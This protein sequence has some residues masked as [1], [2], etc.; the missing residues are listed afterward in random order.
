MLPEE[1]H[2]LDELRECFELEQTYHEQSPAADSR[3]FFLPG[4][5]FSLY[6]SLWATGHI[7]QIRDESGTLCAAL[8]AVPPG[9]EI[10]TRLFAAPGMNLPT[11]SKSNPL[12]PERSV[13]IAKIMTHPDWTRQGLARQLYED[14]FDKF[15]NYTFVTA[16]ALSP[17]RNTVS[18]AFHARIGFLQ[19]GFFHGKKSGTDE[20]TINTL[21]LKTSD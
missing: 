6:E 1:V 10:V 7:R 14:L 16:T 19:A 12:T 20:D 5:L 15:S 11:S 18:E 3:G 8:I 9:H 2:T 17:R 4:T 21:W 13:W